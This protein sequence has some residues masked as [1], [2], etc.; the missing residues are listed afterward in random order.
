LSRNFAEPVGN[1]ILPAFL[2]Y[3]CL[4]DRWD[5]IKPRPVEPKV[6]DPDQIGD[7]W[8]EPLQDGDLPQIKKYFQSIE[9]L[10]KVLHFINFRVAG[11]D[12]EVRLGAAG[13]KRGITFE[14]PRNSL[15][16]TIQF[17][18]FDDLLIGNFMKTTL[19]GAWRTG[20]LYPD[21]TP[22]VGK[23]ADNGRAKTG[24]ELEIYFK[25]YK[26][27]AYF[28]YMRAQIQAKSRSM[29]WHL[30]PENSLRFELAKRAYHQFQAILK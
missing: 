4:Q 2:R 10:K 14:V 18:I 25:E 3:D 26:R 19:H 21:F 15:M 16:T 8:Q 9:H 29:I 30:L 11:R 13:L 17:E 24:A 12:H 28:D 23:Y 1:Q 22:Y 7:S 27:R 5:E 6:V 20:K